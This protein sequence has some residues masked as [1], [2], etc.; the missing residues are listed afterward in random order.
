LSFNQLS[1]ALPPDMFAQYRALI[2]LNLSGNKFSGPL[3]PS[4]TCLTRLQ[5]P[6]SPI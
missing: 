6:P 1:G 3:P 2:E 4:T 5:V